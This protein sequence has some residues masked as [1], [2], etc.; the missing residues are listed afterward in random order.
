MNIDNDEEYEIIEKETYII[1]DIEL[2]DCE[3][4]IKPG[5]PYSILGLEGPNPFIQ[6]GSNT[7]RGEYDQTS[8]TDMIFEVDEELKF[9]STSFKRL[10]TI[11]VQLEKK[12]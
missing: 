2:K 5:D 1:L 12:Q 11:G 8:G 6:I 7:L 3:R 4:D 9:V 10:R